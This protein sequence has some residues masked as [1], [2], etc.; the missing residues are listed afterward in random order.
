MVLRVYHFQK[1]A[2]L[3][4]T[5]KLPD[6]SIDAIVALAKQKQIK[7]VF[8]TEDLVLIKVLRQEKCY[9]N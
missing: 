9:D 2:F 3:L 7:M 8:S 1:R 6:V 5:M 4:T